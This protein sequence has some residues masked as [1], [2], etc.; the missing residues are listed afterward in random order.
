MWIFSLQ[1]E[2][3]S[4]PSPSSK[5][6]IAAAAITAEENFPSVM[7]NT[8]EQEKEGILIKETTTTRW[9]NV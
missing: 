6:H 2:L 4:F 7:T 9:K 5:K 8:R 1:N 3:L